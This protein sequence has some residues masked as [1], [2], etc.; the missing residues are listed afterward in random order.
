MLGWIFGEVKNNVVN[1][2]EYNKAG[3]YLELK[4]ARVRWFLSWI[5]IDIPQEFRGKGSKDIQINVVEGGRDRIQWRDYRPSYCNSTGKS[6]KEEVSDS[7][8][9]GNP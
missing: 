9:R 5:S 2:S 4:N 8:R 3:G 7:I 1:I 6:L